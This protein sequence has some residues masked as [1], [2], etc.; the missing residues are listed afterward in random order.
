MPAN[1]PFDKELSPK[2]QL[3]SNITFAVT[4]ALVVLFVVYV[5]M[6]SGGNIKT[7]FPPIEIKLSEMQDEN[8]EFVELE[9]NLLEKTM[10]SENFKEIYPKTAGLLTE[11]AP[12]VNKYYADNTIVLAKSYNPTKDTSQV[13][14]DVVLLP[15]INEEEKFELTAIKRF[16][17][18]YDKKTNVISR[19]SIR[20]EKF[21]LNFKTISLKKRGDLYDVEYKMTLAAVINDKQA[22][23]DGL[24]N[25]VLHNTAVLKREADS[26][27][28]SGT[29]TFGIVD[30]LMTDL[31][32]DFFDGFTLKGEDLRDITVCINAQEGENGH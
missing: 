2:R 8:N 24:I 3:L 20:K 26:S 6:K 19:V 32:Y 7:D 23:S 31:I 18:E 11:A 9:K 17:M 15:M 5:F 14:L 22:A 27:T 21:Q 1:N 13:T 10:Y 12:D 4:V 16:T 29:A 28:L 25:C 30:I